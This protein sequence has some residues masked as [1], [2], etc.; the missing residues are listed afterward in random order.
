MNDSVDCPEDPGGVY[1]EGEHY[2]NHRDSHDGPQD[3]EVLGH[4]HNVILIIGLLICSHK[5]ELKMSG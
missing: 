1:H 4:F 2:G 3:S 5:L